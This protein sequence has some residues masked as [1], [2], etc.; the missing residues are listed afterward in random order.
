MNPN[1][2]SHMITP[3]LLKACEEQ[4]QKYF[5][6]GDF[7]EHDDCLICRGLELW[8]ACSM[9][10]LGYPNA[11]GLPCVDDP[12]FIDQGSRLTASKEKL[13][14][15]GNRLIEILGEHGIEIYDAEVSNEKL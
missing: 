6:E 15:R 12:T 14:A 13:L 3:N 7:D 4:V 2:K 1:F 10:P 11:I 8:R 9:C 5:G